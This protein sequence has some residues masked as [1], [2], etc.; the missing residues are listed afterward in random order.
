MTKRTRGWAFFVQVVGLLSFWAF[1]ITV[2]V[3]FAWRGPKTMRAECCRFEGDRESVRRQSV[4]RALE[5]LL[6]IVAQDA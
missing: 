5:G 3:W 2:T 6:A 1:A 4:A